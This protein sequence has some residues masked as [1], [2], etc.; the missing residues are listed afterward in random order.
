MMRP[1]CLFAATLATLAACSEERARVPGAPV[2]EPTFTDMPRRDSG[3]DDDDDDAGRPPG[4]GTIG[5][6]TRVTGPAAGAADDPF[7]TAITAPGDLKLTRQT[8]TW[9]ESCNDLR[10]ILEFSD[11]LCPSGSG[12]SLR[13]SFGYQDMLDGVLIGGNNRIGPESDSPSVP[14]RYTRPARLEPKGTWGTCR[15]ADGFIVFGEAPDP[16]P[17][18]YLQA[19]FQLELTPCDTA[20]TETQFVEGAFRVLLRTSASEACPP[21]GGAGGARS[22]TG[23]GGAGAGGADAVGL[24]VFGAA[25]SVGFEG[26]GG[27]GAG[28]VGSGAAGFGF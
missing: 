19:R 14:I 9:S 2:T 25:G 5:L 3:T 1:A 12:H 17:G 16:Q 26:L 6:C 24:D 18:K 8:E 27:T 23:S 7:A 4:P 22:V 13:F 21:T 20:T 11:G 28:G 15:G 10:L